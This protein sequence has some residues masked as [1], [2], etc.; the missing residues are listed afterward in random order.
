MK[1][2]VDTNVLLDLM[3]DRPEFRHAS[4][5]CIQGLRNHGAA[6]YIS[7]LTV[8]HAYYFMRKSHGHEKSMEITQYTLDMFNV[9]PSD[10]STLQRSMSLHFNDLEDAHQCAIA[11]QGNC[12]YFVTRDLK[13]FKKAPLTILSPAEMFSHLNLNS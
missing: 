2:F 10:A 8:I 13:D 12:D 7:S 3:L 5:S 11:L 9:L 1:V 6:L 4:A